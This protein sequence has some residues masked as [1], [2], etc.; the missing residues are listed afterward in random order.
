MLSTHT[1]GVHALVKD[2]HVFPYISWSEYKSRVRFS[3][4]RLS[5]IEKSCISP[6]EKKWP[7]MYKTKFCRVKKKEILHKNTS[8]KEWKCSQSASYVEENAPSNETARTGY[9]TNWIALIGCKIKSQRAMI[10]LTVINLYW[11]RRT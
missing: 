7:N 6:V 1:V 4:K 5:K 8:P 3:F 11:A 10:V 2:Y 9:L